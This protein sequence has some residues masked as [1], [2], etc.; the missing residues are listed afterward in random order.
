M[1]TYVRRWKSPLGYHRAVRRSIFFLIY[2]N[3]MSEYTKHS[4]VT[5]FADDTIIYPTLTIENDCQKLQKDLQA[6]PLE[7]WETDWLMEW[8]A[9]WL[10]EFH[11]DKC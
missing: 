9:D 2:I 8:E 3:N 7:R 10:I 5:L 4:S 1:E 11:P 6:L